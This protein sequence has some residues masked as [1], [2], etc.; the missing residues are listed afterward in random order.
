MGAGS[1][2]G[3]G[4][5]L[6]QGRAGGLSPVE[7]F[8]NKRLAGLTPFRAVAIVR[9]VFLRGHHRREVRPLVCYD[10][11]KQVPFQL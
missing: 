2:R 4:R 5:G 10:L 1:A 9:A 11:C 8:V 7:F 3:T 6:G